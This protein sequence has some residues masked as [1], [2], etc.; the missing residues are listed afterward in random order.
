MTKALLAEE[1]HGRIALGQRTQEVGAGHI[2]G[3]A[4]DPDTGDIVL[5]THAGLFRLGADGPT[6]VGPDVDLMGFA[7]SPDGSYLG[8]GHPGPGSDLGQPVGLI[9]ST[10]GGRTWTTLSRS[11]ESDF[12]G[13]TAGDGLVAGFDGA[14]RVSADGRSWRTVAIPAEPHVLAASP[15]G[16]RLLATTP[17]G[18]LAST[19]G[20]G[21]WSTVPTP[22]LLVAVDWVDADTD[23]YGMPYIYDHFRWEHCVDEG[24]VFPDPKAARANRNTS[25]SGA[26]GVLVGR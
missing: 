8:S 23:G 11:G 14:L 6:P 7:I 1:P 26:S 2:H 20:G 10:D 17:D 3:V 4:R 22:E 9:R 21:T 15:A 24:F 12:H 16:D 13:L 18:L 5:A 19:D 25:S